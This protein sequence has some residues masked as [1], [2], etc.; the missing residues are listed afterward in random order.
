MEYAALKQKH[1]TLEA[2]AGIAG[3]STATMSRYLKLLRL[4]DEIQG[5]VNRGELPVKDPLRS[6]RS[7]PVRKPSMNGTE[8]KLF[9]L[10]GRCL[11]I[12]QQ[13]AADY[14]G[15][16]YAQGGVLLRT[17]VAM[18]LVEPNKEFSPY[19]YTLTNK[20]FVISE[21]GKPKHFMSANAIHQRLMRNSIEL[22]MRERNPKA[23]FVERK[24]AW[25]MGL[26][27]AI[28]EHLIGYE[29]AGKWGYALVVIDDYHMASSRLPHMLNKLHD[30]NKTKASGA[31]VLRWRD[32][33]DTV[34]L[35][36][37]DEIHKKNHERYIQKKKSSLDMRIVV[38]SI[39]PIWKVL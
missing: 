32:V 14:L 33:V 35:Y 37:T 12:T 27:P 29:M 25:S 28:G 18:G 23:T 30:T 17:L 26:F 5:K 21:M 11:F 38:R 15:K 16:S 19:A 1:G 8:S 13:Q 36:V 9:E 10:V 20:G 4:P 39:Q 6:L 31:H 22:A 7:K 2:A 34:V 3:V 24:H